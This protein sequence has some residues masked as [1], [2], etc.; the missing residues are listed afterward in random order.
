MTTERTGPTAQIIQFPA[1]GRFITGGQNEQVA[2]A[3][4]QVSD[5]VM[6]DAW[7]HNAAIRESKRAGE[8]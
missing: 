1:R 6:G 5:S 3:A 7:Y 4:E 2:A 8:R